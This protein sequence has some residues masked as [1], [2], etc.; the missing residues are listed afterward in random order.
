[1]HGILFFEKVHLA[2]III[3]IIY[4]LAFYKIM[5]LLHM[6]ASFRFLAWQAHIFQNF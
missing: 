3:I 5:K 6:R 1:M 4:N 2:I